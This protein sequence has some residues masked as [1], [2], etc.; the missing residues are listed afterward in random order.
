MSASIHRLDGDTEQYVKRQALLYDAL[1]IQP[2]AEGNAIFSSDT[3]V[4]REIRRNGGCSAYRA[5][6][7]DRRAWERTLR[8]KLC[9]LARHAKL[10]QTTSRTSLWDLSAASA[11]RQS[12]T[13]RSRS[14]IVP[15]PIQW[16]YS[17][18]TSLPV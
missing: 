15:S 9:R 1:G 3:A 7:A 5:G 2:D 12:A 18:D 10:L 8:P 11:L 4:S 6:D 14:N 13:N 17:A 16:S